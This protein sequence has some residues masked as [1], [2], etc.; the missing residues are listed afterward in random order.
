MKSSLSEKVGP[1]DGQEEK[2]QLI[3]IDLPSE[4]CLPITKETP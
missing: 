2:L 3:A 1:I 4:Q